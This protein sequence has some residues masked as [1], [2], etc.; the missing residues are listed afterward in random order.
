MSLVTAIFLVVV[1]SALGV[2]MVGLLTRQQASSSMDER[3][4]RAYQ[5]ARAGIEWGLFQQLRLNSCQPSIQLAMP[6]TA[7]TL[8]GFAV[9]VACVATPT[10]ASGTG[11]SPGA[12]QGTLQAGSA[13]VTA[14][15]DTGV[16]VEGMRV[17]GT[18]IAAGTRIAAVSDTYVTLTNAATVTGTFSL[19]YSSALERWQVTSTACT[20]AGPGGCPNPAPAGADYVQRQLQVEF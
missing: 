14:I 10:P 11:A 6:A 19:N 7:P 18:G 5:A 2:A 9:T 4:A 3:G 1:L 13:D 12:V 17:S 16:L 8:A 20:E 15:A